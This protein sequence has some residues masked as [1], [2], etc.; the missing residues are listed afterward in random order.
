MLPEKAR[1]SSVGMKVLLFENLK[2]NGAD[3]AE[4]LKSLGTFDLYKFEQFMYDKQF[5]EFKAKLDAKNIRLMLD[6]AIGVNPTGVDV[7]ANKDIFLLDRDF[8]PTKTSGSPPEPG[9]DYTQTWGH[10]LCDY[11]SPRFW[12]YQEQSVRKL[13]NEGDLRLDHF[14]G[15]INRAEIPLS[16]TKEDGTVLNG[17]LMFKPLSEG[18]MGAQFFKD[19]WIVRVDKK[20]NNKGENMFELF[21]R[22]AQQAGMKPEDCYVLEDFGPLGETAAYKEFKENFGKDFVSQRV[23]IGTGIGD[24]L[25]KPHDMNNSSNP[26]KIEEQ[27][28]TAILTGNHDKPTMKE[29]VDKL[30]DSEPKTFYKSKNS[31][32]LFREFCK[33]ELKL[34]TE[35]MKNHNLV[36][37]ELMK[38]HYT[39]N[40]K[41]VQATLQ[42]ALGLYFRPNI[43][44]FWNGMEDKYLMKPTKEGLLPFWSRVFPKGFLDRTDKSGINS[45]YKDLAQE[46]IETM[47]ELYK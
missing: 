31:P 10:A 11:D 15:Y 14:V 6:L 16:C 26:Y 35:E 17:D 38:W 5:K 3:K 33:K 34:T 37:K 47:Q 9:Y 8:N 40:V 28:N 44:G 41:Q 25:T 13:I 36:V 29:Y 4:I 24:D 30:L 1:N 45:G 20:T 12:D 21:K 23:P 7:W 19:E 32:A 42:D 27:G 18:G 2:K 22:V 46:Y 43:P 39:R